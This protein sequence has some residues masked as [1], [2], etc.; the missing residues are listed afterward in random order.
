VVRETTTDLTGRVVEQFA[1][2]KEE[3]VVGSVPDTVV[4][5]DTRRAELLGNFAIPVAKES[6]NTVIGVL[7]LKRA[8]GQ[9]R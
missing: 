2:R 5:D 4:P 3:G 1:Y 7:G 6:E 9:A 8:L